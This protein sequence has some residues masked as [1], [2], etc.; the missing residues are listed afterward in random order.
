MDAVEK[1]IGTNAVSEAP[2]MR[3]QGR[4]HDM[5]GEPFKKL[6]FYPY[7]NTGCFF[8]ALCLVFA[9]G[10]IWNL[11]E[12]ESGEKWI[13]VA[14]IL[15]FLLLGAIFYF[16]LSELK[17][18]VFT[19]EEIRIRAFFL[20]R[21]SYRYSDIDRAV[22]KDSVP[23]MTLYFKDGTRV[24]GLTS[25]RYR[26][27]MLIDRLYAYQIEVK[28]PA[29]RIV[30]RNIMVKREKRN[31]EDALALVQT[32]AGE[33]NQAM[34]ETKA[35]YAGAGVVIEDGILK[36]KLPKQR[37]GYSYGM[38]FKKDGKYIVLSNRRYVQADFEL[39]RGSDREGYQCVLNYMEIFEDYWSKMLINSYKELKSMKK[40]PKLSE[41]APEEPF[42]QLERNSDKKENND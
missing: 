6:T 2:P 34:E 18:V 3:E 4:D 8:L 11:T 15:F 12:H 37:E 7:R 27:R 38:R 25:T 24:R 40:Q 42:L 21:R 28:D 14:V 31:R 35:L 36:K 1:K 29:G 33:L 32:A 9:F 22:H 13:D 10:G 23:V 16:G 30:P 39:A 26:Y 41:I 19:E 17:K 20:S 5:Q